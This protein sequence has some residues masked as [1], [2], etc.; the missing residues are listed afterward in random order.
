MPLC[1]CVLPL[2]IKKGFRFPLFYISFDIDQNSINGSVI[3]TAEMN[4]FCREIH[5]SFEIDFNFERLESLIKT[6]SYGRGNFGIYEVNRV[7]NRHN[8]N[9]N[10]QKNETR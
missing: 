1:V 8:V 7:M 3:R 9:M 6:G 10:I 4:F 5:L 2:T